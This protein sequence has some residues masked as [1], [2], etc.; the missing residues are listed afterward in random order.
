MLWVDD[1]FVTAADLQ[2]MDSEVA[3]V[4]QTEGIVLEGSNG[5]I[6]RA[7]E[8]AQA[9]LSKFM[10]FSGLNP[11]DLT[12]RDVNMPLGV[13]DLRYNYA[14]FA[15]L[16]IS[17]EVSD[18]WSALKQWVVGRTLL[19]FYRAATNKNSDR[20]SDRY[21]EMQADVRER[22]WPNFK[23]RGIPIV[24]NPL[25]A[26]GAIMERAGLFS[27][28]NNL[29]L[30]SGSGTLDEDTV[31]AITWVGSK[32]VSATAKHNNESYRSA[33]VTLPL[34]SGNVARVTTTG[35]TAPNGS[36]PEFTKSSCRYSPG[37]AVGWNVWAGRATEDVMYRQNASVIPLATTSYTFTGNPVYSGEQLDL[38]QYED[39]ILEIRNELVRA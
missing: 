8:D 26:P 23:R 14:S 12:V 30:V 1:D 21:E 33:R 31:I 5:A 29:S 17:G 16:V 27:L 22:I 24:F 10:S 32:Y 39:I 4:A 11:T 2:S 25:P 34:I 37:T 15:Q 28:D 9:T 38:G 18:N 20:Y 19:R 3:D 36:Q 35:L 13:P 6:R 7:K